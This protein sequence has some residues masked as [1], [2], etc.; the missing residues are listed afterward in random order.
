MFEIGQR[1]C[2][3]A[4]K[5]KRGRV[6]DL[7][8]KGVC[9]I[10]WD[11]EDIETVRQS[12]I[13]NEIITK[14]PWE[15]LSKNEFDDY[16]NFTISSIINKVR[17]TSANTISTLKASKTIFKPY[18]FIPLLKLLNSENKRIIVA[19][20]VG[21]GKTISAGHIV[22]ELAARGEL[23]NL[24]VVCLNSIQEK[25]IDE[26]QNK[27]NV[28]IERFE[29]IQDFKTA[30][31]NARE[32]NDKI[33]G[34]INYDKFRQ[35]KNV[36]YFENNAI[37]FDL[38]IFDEVHTLRNDTNAR[39]SLK[40]FTELANSIV[41]L[42]ATPIM[43]SL[44]NLYSLVRLLDEDN[45]SNYQIFQ[46]AININKPFIRAYNQ[47]NAGIPTKEIAEELKTVEVENVFKYGYDEF[48]TNVPLSE[49]LADD[50]LYHRIIQK[51]DNIEPI[52]VSQKVH[53][54]EMLINLNSLNHF[55][56]R[57]RKSE[58]LTEGNII[59]RNANVVEIE[60]NDDEQQL[61]DEVINTVAE[62]IGGIQIKRKFAS[63][64]FA[65]NYTEEQYSKG[66][67][68]I[69][70]N[71]NK[72]KALLEIISRQENNRIIVFAFFKKTLM[73]LKNRLQND[74]HKAGL[75]FGGV[76]MT[77][78]NKI[79]DSFKNNEFQILLSSEVGSTGLDMQFCDR[80][81]NYDLPWNPMVVEQ[82]I[83]RIDRIGQQSEIINIFN[84]IYKDTI[85]E[86]IYTRLF[87]RIG[88]FK[89]ALGNLDEILG[90]KEKYIEGEIQK[91]YKENLSKAEINERLD[92]I[93]AAYER[94]K[95]DLHRIDIGLKDSFSN[96]LY[97]ENEI[98]AIEK[99]KQ[100][101]TETDLA[102]FIERIIAN[103]LTTITF[104]Q[105]RDNKLIFEIT[106]PNDD[107]VFD[108]IEEFYDKHNTE[109][110]NI[111]KSF[112]IK[113]RGSLIKFTFNQDFAFNYKNVEYISAYHPFINA[114]SNYFHKEKLDRNTI[115]R[116]ALNRNQIT[117][118][119][120]NNKYKNGFYFLI[121]YDFE[122]DKTINGR[123]STFTHL[124]S[125]ALDLNGNE[126]TALENEESDYFA[127][128]CQQFKSYLPEEGVITFSEDLTNE[129]KKKFAE[130]VLNEK[131]ILEQN[132]K[133][134][135]DSELARKTKQEI[136][137]IDKKIS[138]ET[139]RL[140]NEKLRAIQL[141]ENKSRNLVGAITS[142][143]EELRKRKEKL[144]KL[145]Q[146]SKI[147]VKSKL[148][149]LNFIYLYG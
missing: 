42:T 135:F 47:L 93:A 99:N 10:I 53:L 60:M 67:K 4:D 21:L 23:N 91:I 100:Y 78:R 142:T 58:V 68:D 71:D 75:I 66:V 49:I 32:Q 95:L 48:T 74:G 38:M 148:I 22:L 129:I 121:K 133:L 65:D 40:S 146:E 130:F 39:K 141:T 114:I 122:I 55:Y 54:Q 107:T 20:E 79:I 90:E 132:E 85:E 117:E 84:F 101:L 16:R 94:N 104:I 83:G 109:L 62:D 147:S 115:F 46:N 149:S 36:E 33:F 31:Q 118:T 35:R 106:Q 80:M 89:E 69:S 136:Y 25:W 120:F 131:D 97:F 24:L 123:L 51:L 140:E 112:K 5:N 76:D 57:T 28:R 7:P 127:S 105:S 116:Y 139:Q 2:L 88:L 82:R 134:K 111:F 103:K 108:F 145:N 17:N 13:Q 41:M 50:N 18:Q 15:R 72:Y 12:I 126:F 92:R 137:D 52:T 144:E 63:S 11:N 61:Y 14:T 87:N 124:K 56:T 37:S 98:R 9:E 110:T 143:I 29:R 119:D 113:N 102:E 64:L 26:L 30:L 19:D 34:V 6:N 125:L 96:D 1:I 43:T 77:E 59:R 70:D 86:Q 44:E 81:V 73:Y 27:F 128:I 138:K 3:I 45:Y 8:S